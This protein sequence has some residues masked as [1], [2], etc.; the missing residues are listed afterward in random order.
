M[1]FAYGVLSPTLGAVPCTC[2]VIGS[3]LVND[4]RRL[5]SPKGLHRLDRFSAYGIVVA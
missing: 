1:H 2:A 4:S 3:T 5:R